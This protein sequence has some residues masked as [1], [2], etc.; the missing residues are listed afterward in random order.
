MRRRATTSANALASSLLRMA[1]NDARPETSGLSTCVMCHRDMVV[2]V[3]W[4]TVA[5][6][7]WWIFVRCAHCGISREV[8]VT[9]EVARRYD[10]ELSVGTAAIRRAADRLEQERM[11]A[12][13][14]HFVAALE[15]DL[16]EPSDFAR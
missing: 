4:D 2:P 1:A 13:V 16:I 14:E 9:D 3:E 15:R 5:G 10:D 12:E 11:S 6:E 7:R 8:V